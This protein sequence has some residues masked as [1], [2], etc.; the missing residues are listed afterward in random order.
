M[1]ALSLKSASFGDQKDVSAAPEVLLERARREAVKVR[2]PHLE[3]ARIRT[4]VREIGGAKAMM[5][6]GK[7]MPPY[8]LYL[9]DGHYRGLREVYLCYGSDEVLYAA[10][11]SGRAGT[12]AGW[13]QSQAGNR[14][15]HVPLLSVFSESQGIKRSLGSHDRLYQ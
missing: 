10:C 6:K 8:M 9:E 3:D 11:G 4:E 13:S 7:D 2:I 15:R 12:E 1:A 5:T 14:E